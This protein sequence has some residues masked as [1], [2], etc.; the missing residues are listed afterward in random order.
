MKVETQSA[1]GS[2]EAWQAKYKKTAASAGGMDGREMLCTFIGSQWRDALKAMEADLALVGVA[3]V[4]PADSLYPVIVIALDQLLPDKARLTPPIAAAVATTITTGQRFRHH[5]KIVEAQKHDP[6]IQEYKRKAEEA[7][8]AARA[9]RVAKA[10]QDGI[11][12]VPA[13]PPPVQTASA[14]IDPIEPTLGSTPS[15]KATEPPRKQ[16]DDLVF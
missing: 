7:E 11:K 8:K 16:S 3:P 1:G 12:S 9:E 15:S 5:K 6:S 4:I 2:G 10:A 14:P 13:D